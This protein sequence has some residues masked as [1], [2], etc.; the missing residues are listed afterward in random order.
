MPRLIFRDEH[1][2]QFLA[3]ANADDLQGCIRSDGARQ[4]GDLGAGDFGNKDFAAFHLLNAVN[5]EAHTLFQ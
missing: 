2:V 1:L 5:H 4:V 3:G